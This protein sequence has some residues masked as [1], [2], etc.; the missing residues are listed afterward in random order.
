MAEVWKAHDLRLDRA[1]A[2]KMPLHHLRDR[3]EFMERFRREAVAAA[4]LNHPRV[5]GVYDTGSD[6]ELGG[7][8]VM[9]LVDGPSLKSLMA[10]GGPLWVERSGSLAAE[11]AAALDFARRRGIVHRD[12][13]PANVLV[14]PDGAKVADFGIAK[15]AQ[16]GEDLT[17][18]SFTLG[19]A[20]YLSP[21]QVQG[22]AVD[23]RSDVYSLG[24]VLYEMLA[25]RTPF[26]ADSELALALKHVTATP[27]PPSCL[28]PLVPGWLDAVV[29]TALA[30]DPADRFPTA[31]EMRSALT[32]PGLPPAGGGPA[33]ADRR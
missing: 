2:V 27:E 24:V 28:N 11:V 23:A 5:V 14:A 9:E 31:A 33:P 26:D 1:V 17:Q 6:P 10:E 18:T 19:T 29:L 8:I 13:K 32:G 16:R 20:R 22:E 30:K 7:Y 25:G 12:V 3:P 21:E 15:A 4:R